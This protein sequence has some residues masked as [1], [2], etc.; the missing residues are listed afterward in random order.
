VFVTVVAVTTAVLYVLA[1]VVVLAALIY[2]MFRRSPAAWTTIA[3]VGAV[4]AAVNAAAYLFDPW[5]LYGLAAAIWLLVA[6]TAAVC[7]RCDTA[8]PRPHATPKETP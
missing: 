7:R 6:V 3:V 4:M 2:R 5:P 1:P 8:N